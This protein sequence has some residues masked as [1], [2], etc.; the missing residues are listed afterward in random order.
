M[1]LS[2]SFVLKAWFYGNLRLY[3]GSLRGKRDVLKLRRVYLCSA[4]RSTLCSQ[5]F[6]RVNE[7]TLKL[8]AVPRR[9]DKRTPQGL[10]CKTT[11]AQ[12]YPFGILSAPSPYSFQDSRTSSGMLF[13]QFHETL[14]CFRGKAF[15]SS[16]GMFSSA[17]C[18]SSGMA[19]NSGF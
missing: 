5:D 6:S 3:H 4:P 7:E 12:E 10:E 9:R 2:G 15:S 13:I 16:F 8:G 14:S 11:R 18:F 1:Y 17:C 19:F